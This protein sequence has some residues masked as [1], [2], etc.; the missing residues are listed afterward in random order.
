MKKKLL[1]CIIILLLC[2]MMYSCGKRK[3][4]SETLEQTIVKVA[5][6]FQEKDTAIINSL[7]LKEKGLIVLFRIGTFDQY[8]QIKTFDFS[9]LTPGFAPIAS[10]KTDFKVRFESLPTFDCDKM[11]WSKSGIYCDTTFRD[12]L[13]SETATNLKTYGGDTISAKGIESFV[14]LEKTSRRIVLSD[15][16]GGALV[17]YL[18]LIHNKWYLTLLDRV[19]SDCS[20]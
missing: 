12:K 1:P 4:N 13:L 11:K 2:G 18:S 20:A 5:K 7:I 17:F 9:Q 19:T 15:T 3:A 6:A 8:T 14:E 16:E 10:F